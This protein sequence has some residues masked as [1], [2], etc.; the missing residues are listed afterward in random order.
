MNR[1]Q[2]IILFLSVA[3]VVVFG[4][5]TLICLELRKNNFDIQSSASSIESPNE[6]QNN[7]M[8]GFN[9]S[10]DNSSPQLIIQPEYP[11]YND[12]ETTRSF[13]SGDYDCTDFDTQEDAQE[14]YEEEGGPDEDPHNLDRDG[15]G[16]AC[17]TL[18]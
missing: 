8:Q 11:R 16:V 14:F 10:N 3:V 4:I 17:E 1:T 9:G 12:P 6:Y 18:P 13:E 2:R 7:T 15:D 5:Y